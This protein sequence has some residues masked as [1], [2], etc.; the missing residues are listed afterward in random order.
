MCIYDSEIILSMFKLEQWF[1][2]E[3]IK[4][5]FLLLF[6]DRISIHSSGCTGTDVADRADLELTAITCLLLPNYRDK[7]CDYQVWPTSTSY[8]MVMINFIKNIVLIEP[9][10]VLVVF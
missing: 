2:G 10:H 8:G 7:M 4:D 9:K 5:F 1:S 3:E 6:W